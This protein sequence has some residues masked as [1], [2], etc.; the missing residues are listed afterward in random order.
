MLCMPAISSIMVRPEANQTTSTQIAV[1][2]S[3]VCTSQAVWPLTM[4]SLDS[5]KFT[6]PG[7]RL[8]LDHSHE[9][10]GHQADDVRQEEQRAEHRR[11]GPVGPHEHG[12]GV[13]DHEDRDVTM[14]VYF[15]VNRIDCRKTESCT[16]QGRS[17]PGR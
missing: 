6:E 12:E 13:S 14:P 11:P 1:R 17:S 7:C 15:R 8:Q 16:Q 3:P 2:A 10:L 9:A 4:P 5:T